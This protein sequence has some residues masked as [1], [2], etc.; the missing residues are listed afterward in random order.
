MKHFYACLSAI[1]MFLSF[2][3]TAQTV[4]KYGIWQESGNPL[5][6]DSLQV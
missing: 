3:G 5:N 4:L 1:S 2:S 6:I